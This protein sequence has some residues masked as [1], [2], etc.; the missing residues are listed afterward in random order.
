[1]R[2]TA[3]V[4]DLCCACIDSCYRLLLSKVT[5]DYNNWTSND[6]IYAGNDVMKVV[7]KVAIRDHFFG[8]FPLKIGKPGPQPHSQSEPPYQTMQI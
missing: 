3:Y 2:T 5:A 8:T 6:S 4:T 1:M 7:Y